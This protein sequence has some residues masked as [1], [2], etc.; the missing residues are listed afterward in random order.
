MKN[1]I[2]QT[3]LYAARKHPGKLWYT[4][5][6]LFSMQ[7]DA[8]KQVENDPDFNQGLRDLLAGEGWTWEEWHDG[9]KRVA[10]MGFYGVMPEECAETNRKVKRYCREWGMFYPDVLIN[11]FADHCKNVIKSN[12]GGVVRRK[13]ED[14]LWEYAILSIVTVQYSRM[15]KEKEGVSC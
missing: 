2:H 1:K 11:T 12:K 14:G 13:R 3:L 9:V 7:E 5:R 6:E 10:K 15:Y 8:V 4:M